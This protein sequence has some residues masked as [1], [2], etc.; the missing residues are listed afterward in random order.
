MNTHQLRLTIAVI[1]ATA[2]FEAS[3]CSCFATSEIDLFCKA[4][5]VFVAEVHAN[6][7]PALDNLTRAVE[8]RAHV[9]RQYKGQL[10]PEVRLSVE[11]RMKRVPSTRRDL[12]D[13]T[14]VTSCS[15]SLKVPAIYLIYATD[16]LVTLRVCAGIGSIDS[17][18][19]DANAGSRA[20][21]QLKEGRANCK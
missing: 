21:E 17:S 18:E 8:G 2:T 4:K 20:A 15:W 9:L 5:Y 12:P 13:V 16:S 3:A 11:D 10:D 7:V 14:T 19:V 1:F 6:D